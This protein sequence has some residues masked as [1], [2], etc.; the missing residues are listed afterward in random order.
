MRKDKKDRNIHT[1]KEKKGNMKR[2]RNRRNNGEEENR[3]V[4]QMKT[5]KMKC[6]QRE[7][8]EKHTHKREKE[9]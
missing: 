4:C 5:V 6:G 9:E 8:R 1:Q 2:K 3:A 7:T